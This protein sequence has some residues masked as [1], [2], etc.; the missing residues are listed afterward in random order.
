MLGDVLCA[1]ILLSRCW[2]RKVSDNASKQRSSFY[3]NRKDGFSAR[4]SCF[5]RVGVLVGKS[6]NAPTRWRLSDDPLIG[7]AAAAVSQNLERG[8][9]SVLAAQV[10]RCSQAP[11]AAAA[12][13]GAAPGHR[14]AGPGAPSIPLRAAAR[15]L[16]PVRCAGPTRSRAAVAVADPV[17]SADPVRVRA[18]AQRSSGRSVAYLHW[19]CAESEWVA[20]H[21]ASQS[22]AC[23]TTQQSLSY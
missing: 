1:S 9:R 8:N 6:R 12:A 7:A 16:D 5:I 17:R 10:Q 15:A 4:E 11:A 3:P 22:S 20:R 14:V 21:L 18:D 2:R 13:T 23:D 19:L